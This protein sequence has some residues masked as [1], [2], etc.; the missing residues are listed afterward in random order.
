MLCGYWN[1]GTTETLEYWINCMLNNIIVRVQSESKLASNTL[2]KQEGEISALAASLP[3]F[4]NSKFPKQWIREHLLQWQA[5]LEH[6]S[7]FLICEC[8]G[9]IMATTLNFL[10]VLKRMTPN[11]K[12]LHC[13]TFEHTT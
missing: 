9:K 7:D 1:T 2:Q 12:D 10:M 11:K 13:I 6:I 8:G 3:P 5:H 4:T